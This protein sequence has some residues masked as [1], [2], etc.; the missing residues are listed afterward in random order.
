MKEDEEQHDEGHGPGEVA[1][2]L[3]VLNVVRD[4]VIVSGEDLS[5]RGLLLRR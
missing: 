5:V 1:R 3:P 2:I 4:E